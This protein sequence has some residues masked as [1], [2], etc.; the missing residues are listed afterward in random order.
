MFNNRNNHSQ[1]PNQ[2]ERI[3]TLKKR[4]LLMY[5]PHKRSGLELWKESCSGELLRKAAL[6]KR[7]GGCKARFKSGS[8]PAEVSDTM[9]VRLGL[10]VCV[11]SAHT[12][13]LSGCLVAA[14]KIQRAVCPSIK[15]TYWQV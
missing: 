3:C 11:N 6:S 1:M 7:G 15:N 9:K 10:A 2:E 13:T 12:D 8:F 14:G 5:M 4:T